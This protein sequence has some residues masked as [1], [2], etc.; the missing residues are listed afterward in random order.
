[1][2]SDPISPPKPG[3]AHPSEGSVHAPHCASSI[4]QYRISRRS[5]MGIQTA[6]LRIHPTRPSPIQIGDI[7]LPICQFAK[8][9]I[10]VYI[11]LSIQRAIDL[12]IYR[13]ISRR[14]YEPTNLPIGISLFRRRPI[15]LA[16]YQPTNL[17]ARQSIDLESIY[18]TID[19]SP[20]AL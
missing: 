15:A 12:S 19:L 7:F 3:F 5:I 20:Y 18:L 2:G 17:S 10:G 11:H 8:P 16:I 14:I 13:P 9:S 4:P 1:M 6:L